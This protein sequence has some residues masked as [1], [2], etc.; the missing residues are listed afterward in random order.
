MRSIAVGRSWLQEIVH[1]SSAGPDDIA[2]RENCSRRH[3]TMMISLAFIAPDLV[4]AACMG[5]C[6][7][8]LV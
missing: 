5:G 6:R 8:V 7:A 4:T 1:G 3:V 2:A